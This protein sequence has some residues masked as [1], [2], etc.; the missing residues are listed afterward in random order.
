MLTT[1]KVY[2]LDPATEWSEPEWIDLTGVRQDGTPI[3][4][5]RDFHFWEVLHETV[6]HE[7]AY[8]GLP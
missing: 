3:A 4:Y 5:E 2:P 8:Q 7:P 1:I 6:D